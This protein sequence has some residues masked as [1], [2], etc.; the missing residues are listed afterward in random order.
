MRGSTKFLSMFFFLV[1]LV[2]GL[3]GAENSVTHSR[4][5]FGNSLKV[6]TNNIIDL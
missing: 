4:S 2:S 5:E 1:Q 3:S 6:M